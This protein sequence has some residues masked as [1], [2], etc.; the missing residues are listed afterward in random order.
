MRLLLSLVAVLILAAPAQARVCHGQHPFHPY[1]SQAQWELHAYAG[2]RAQFGFRHD[3]AYVQDLIAR[4]QWGD[5]PHDFPATPAERRYLRLRDKLTLGTAAERYL[6]KH[7]DVVGGSD[8][9]DNWPRRPYLLVGFTRDVKQHL[10]ALRRLARFPR[11]V[12][13]R[14]VPLSEQGRERLISRVQ[15][16][17]LTLQQAGF[18]LAFDDEAAQRLEFKVVTRRSDARAYFR[19]RYGPQVRVRVIARSHTRLECAVAHRYKISRDG[20]TLSVW[21]N[22]YYS[23]RPLRIEL[24]E[25]AQR[26]VVGLV[27]RRLTD[28]GID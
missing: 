22:D 20:R 18:S 23:S 10:A 15:G 8:I 3:A 1:P 26:V 28:R 7:A 11:D 24:S 16:D 21:W 13:A 9:K 17:W 5:Y 25:S 6:R 12:R 19:S 27:Q 4:R 14:R 2:D